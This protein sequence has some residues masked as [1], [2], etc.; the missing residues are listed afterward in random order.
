MA[1]VLL[2]VPFLL[3]HVV[4][5]KASC[6]ATRQPCQEVHVQKPENTKMICAF[7]YNHSSGLLLDQNF[8]D[9]LSQRHPAKEYLNSRPTKNVT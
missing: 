7:M 4:L 5:R 1:S 2:L 3:E 6:Y 9:T 8:R